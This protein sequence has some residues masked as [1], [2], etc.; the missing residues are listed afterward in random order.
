MTKER[1]RKARKR[2]IRAFCRNELAGKRLM[3]RPSP[4]SHG[5]PGEGNGRPVNREGALRAYYSAASARG[6]DQLASDSV[7]GF[8]ARCVSKGSLQEA[9]ID[10][11]ARK[12][13]TSRCAADCPDRLHDCHEH[14]LPS[15]RLAE[16]RDDS[17]TR[18]RQPLIRDNQPAPDSNFP[19]RGS[20]AAGNGRGA[21]L[22]DFE[23]RFAT[24]WGNHAAIHRAGTVKNCCAGSQRCISGRIKFAVLS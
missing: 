16:V 4:N 13:V 7:I 19:R 12:G 21:S 2:D 11:G 22:T 15:G 3:S 23:A 24:R 5:S 8:R 6:G 10:R 18:S 14:P 9:G 17:S 1:E 20:V